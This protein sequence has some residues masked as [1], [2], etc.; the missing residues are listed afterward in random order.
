MGSQ[1]ERILGGT[2]GSVVTVT[3]DYAIINDGL[4]SGAVE[5]ISTVAESDKVL[6]IYD[7]D[8]PTGTPESAATFRKVNAFAKKFGT[9][10][11]QA[12][13]T[14]YSWML[15]NK[16][17]PGHI[18]VSGGTHTAIFG[19]IGAIGINVSNTELA[20]IVEKGS[21]SIVVPESVKIRLAGQLPEDVSIMDVA[22]YFLKNTPNIAGKAVEFLPDTS[23]SVHDKSVLCSMACGTGAFTATF[24]EE[25]E[26]VVTLDMGKVSPMVVEPCSNREEQKNAQ[27]S[28]LSVLKGQIFHAGQIGGYTGGSIEDLRLAAQM[29]K[30]KKV[31]LGFRLTVSPATSADYIAALDDGT[32]ETLISYGAQI[33]AAGDH[34]INR[35]GAGVIGSG[36]KLLTTG[37]YTFAGCMGCEDSQVFTAS[38][39]TITKTS[40][41]AKIVDV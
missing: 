34:S 28:P 33:H 38:V 17:R 37:L 8:V 18:V 36:E 11:V 7:H 20:R 26:A 13:G 40:M 21:Y 15:V 25:G 2:Q 4:S 35:Q 41:T 19:A 29:V 23:L 22:L 31:A 16:V 9:T 24:A 39:Q 6:V 12:Q 14:G 30:G 5:M 32:V 1:I 10:F 27:I 3:P